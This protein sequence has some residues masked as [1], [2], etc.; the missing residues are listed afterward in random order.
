MNWLFPVGIG[1]EVGSVVQVCAVGF[2]HRQGKG[3]QLFLLGTRQENG[4]SRSSL[5][6]R[7]KAIN[8][9]LMNF[10]Q[11]PKKDG[12]WLSGWVAQGYA[13][14]EKAPLAA[15]PGGAFQCV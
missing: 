13:G 9:Y 4:C 14:Q 11:F 2:S 8:D 7:T 10:S 1:K 12:A 15:R 6:M 5:L 3:E